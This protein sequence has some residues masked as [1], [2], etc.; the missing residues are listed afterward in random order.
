MREPN[1][2]TF[3]PLPT[4]VFHILIAL[5]GERAGAAGNAEVIARHA[6]GGFRIKPWTLI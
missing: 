1:S 2:D 6:L 4:A 5:A 3:L